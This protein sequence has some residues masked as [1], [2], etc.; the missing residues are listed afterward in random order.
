MMA[1]ANDWSLG[2]RFLMLDSQIVSVRRAGLGEAGDTAT[3]KHPAMQQFSSRR[4]SRVCV[5][6]P[7]ACPQLTLLLDEREGNKLARSES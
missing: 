3:T 6:R 5:L 4:P 2:C 1:N 7:A